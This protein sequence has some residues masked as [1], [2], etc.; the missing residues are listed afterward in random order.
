MA[1]ETTKAA[2]AASD[3]RLRAALEA[4]DTASVQ[5][6]TQINKQRDQVARLGF[7]KAGSARS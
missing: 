3:A 4:G 7:G 5:L 2:S 1:M 6:G